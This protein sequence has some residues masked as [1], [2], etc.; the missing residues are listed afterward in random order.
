LGEDGP[1]DEAELPPPVGGLVHQVR[2]GDVRGH[3][4][5]RELDAAEPQVHRPRQGADH[6]GLRQARHAHQQ[7]VSAH[8]DRGQ[9][10]VED[11]ALAYNLAADFGDEAVAEALELR[12]TLVKT[13]LGHA[14]P[15]HRAAAG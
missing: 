14:K 2:P 12:Q 9:H 6:Q 11:F 5:G 10:L 1:L 3:E 8:E 4:V 7:A 13:L 15:F